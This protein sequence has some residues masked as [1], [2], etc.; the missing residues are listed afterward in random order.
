MRS[1]IAYNSLQAGQG[2]RQQENGRS[3]NQQRCAEAIGKLVTNDRRKCE[4]RN[5][6]GCA[7]NVSCLKETCL[8]DRRYAPA[9]R[10][11]GN[12]LLLRWLFIFFTGKLGLN[13]LRAD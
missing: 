9:R 8:A 3:L 12:H 4:G 5:L 7:R 6:P 11:P 2:T 1:A 13:R 10:R